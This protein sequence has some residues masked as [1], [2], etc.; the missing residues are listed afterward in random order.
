MGDGEREGES[1][2]KDPEELRG[3]ILSKRITFKCKENQES[4]EQRD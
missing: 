3:M 2:L 4:L 1:W